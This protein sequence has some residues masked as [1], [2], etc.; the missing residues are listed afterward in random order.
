MTKFRLCG[1]E[2]VG[3][4]SKEELGE[5]EREGGKEINAPGEKSLYDILEVG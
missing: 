3:N 1:R 4:V 5:R 2:G